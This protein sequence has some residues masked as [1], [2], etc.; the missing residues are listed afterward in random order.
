VYLDYHAT[1]PVD[2]RVLDAMLPFFTERFGNPHS[3]QHAWG[4]DAE[5]AVEKAR[6]QVAALINASPSEITFTGG[7]TESNN[8][9]IK[10]MASRLRDRGSR[11]VTAATEHKSV[12]DTCRRLGA[13]GFDVQVA[14]VQRD[15]TID[16][17]ALSNE[18]TNDTLLVSVM[19]ANNEIGTLQPLGE[20]AAIA[21]EC[22][23]LLHTDAAQAAG[24]VPID[25]R[26]MGIDL[27]SLTGHKMYGP[28][29]CGALFVARRRPKLLPMAQLEGG[30]QEAGVRSGTLNVPGIVGLGAAADVARLEMAEESARLSTLRNDL[31]AR[32]RGSLDGVHVNGT[33]ERRL[34]HNLHVSFERVEGERLLMALG[35]LAV[36]TG[37]ACSSGSQAPSHVLQAIGAAGEDAGASIR[38]GLGRM[39][40][41]EEIEFA[42]DR[43]ITV[44]N[45]LRR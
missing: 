34:P 29:G 16:L 23:A 26:A 27:L 18:V 11:I 31:L 20:I 21:H 22:A 40:T 10:G 15:G 38:F 42:A 2:P 5:K 39:T 3:R 35:D 13:Q 25:V 24:K 33:M 1:T 28:K 36:S 30:G 44:V 6:E 19:A 41:A 14:G 12:L 8:L 45:A 9:A 17:D 32:L 43:V 4:W 37:S 7:A